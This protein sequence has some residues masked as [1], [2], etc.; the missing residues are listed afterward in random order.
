MARADIGFYKTN[1]NSIPAVV[2]DE[3]DADGNAVA[4]AATAASVDVLLLGVD[5]GKRYNVP[6]AASEAAALPNQFAYA[7]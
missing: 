3:W 7:A 6:V 5:Q 4:G 2:L 1:S